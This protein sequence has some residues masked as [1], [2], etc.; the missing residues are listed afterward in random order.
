MVVGW[1]SDSGG[2]RLESCRRVAGW[3]ESGRIVVRSVDWFGQDA[4]SCYYEKGELEGGGEHGAEHV[5][6]ISQ[7]ATDNSDRPTHPVTILALEQV[8]PPQPTQP[9]QATE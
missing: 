2:L 7:T 5:D 1:W 9:T 8:P 4:R 3:S 6:G